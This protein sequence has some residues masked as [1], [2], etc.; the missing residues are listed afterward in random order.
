M[1]NVLVMTDTTAC[2]P[3]DIADKHGIK[4]VPASQIT[5]EGKTYTEGVTIS[6]RQAYDIIKKDPT[7]SAPLR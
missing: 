2:L 5:C 7:V 6:A 4:I 3:K 1:S